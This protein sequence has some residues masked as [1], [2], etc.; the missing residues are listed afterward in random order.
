M[1]NGVDKGWNQDT[2]KFETPDRYKQKD[3]G[4]LID[5]WAIKYSREEFRAIMRAKVDKYYDRYG[6]KDSFVSEAKKAA[7]YANRLYQYE[8]IWASEDNEV[9][10]D[11]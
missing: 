2:P 8:V 10:S 5:K 9:V 7:D 3:G 4:D 11:D 1:T 6:Q